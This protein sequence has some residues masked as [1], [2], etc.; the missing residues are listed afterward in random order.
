MG[1]S[2][3]CCPLVERG[4][5]ACR[6]RWLSALSL[7]EGRGTLRVLYSRPACLGSPDPSRSLNPSGATRGHRYRPPLLTLC[8]VGMQR[9]TPPRPPAPSNP[10]HL[11]GRGPVG[12][13]IA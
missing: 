2:R 12:A 9:S 5:A 8:C 1:G 7:C 13:D 6:G 4:G 3:R 10:A 11:A